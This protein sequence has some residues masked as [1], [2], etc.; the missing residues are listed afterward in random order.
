MPRA[1][2]LYCSAL[3]LRSMRALNLACGGSS[4]PKNGQPRAVAPRWLR[5]RGVRL[6][7]R[8]T[9]A[10]AS[11]AGFGTGIRTE[12][13]PTAL[14]PSQARA[15]RRGDAPRSR[16][17]DQRALGA[18][19]GPAGVASRGKHRLFCAAGT[20]TRC[21][22]PRRAPPRRVGSSIRRA[23]P[24]RRPRQRRAGYTRRR[25]DVQGLVLPR[26][27]GL[28][29]GAPRRPLR[30]R[31]GSLCSPPQ[32]ARRVGAALHCVVPAPAR[33]SNQG[34]LGVST[35]DASPLACA[36][37]RARG[38]R[39]APPPPVWT[40]RGGPGLTRPSRAAGDALVSASLRSSHSLRAARLLRAHAAP[41]VAHR[42][43]LR[44]LR[45][46]DATHG[47]CDVRARAWPP[48]QWIRRGA[49]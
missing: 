23:A 20:A 11:P 48:A 44:T 25:A 46:R 49:A 36:S 13:R 7:G 28:S 22:Q 29:L 24:R 31:V 34:S 8:A 15:P 16:P 40:R 43:D 4:A 47:S 1:A 17:R 2:R 42:A 30:L 37:Q 39:F 21:A 10:R 32:R 14:R 18:R 27:T 38:P 35:R 26:C 45:L 9:R 3:A 5:R 6:F 19:F 41:E 12:P 33:L